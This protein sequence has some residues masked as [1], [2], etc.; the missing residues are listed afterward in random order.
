MPE[1]LRVLLGLGKGEIPSDGVT[2]LELAGLPHGWWAIPALL[3]VVLALVLV[4]LIYRRESELALPQRIVLASLRL[5]ALAL[6]VLVLLNPRLLVEI[7]A[8]RPAQTILLVDGSLSMGT[9]DRY[10]P[11][12]V[13]LLQRATGIRV[14]GGRDSEDPHG[15]ARADLVAAALLWADLPARLGKVNRLRPFIFDEKAM[16]V[17][18]KALAPSIRAA[19]RA[20]KATWL[21]SAIREALDAAGTEQ[22]AAMVV[23]SDGRSNGGD[24]PEGARAELA[25]RGIPVHAIGVGKAE[26]RKNITVAEVTAPEVAEI[27]LPLKVRV[28]VRATGLPGR[29]EVKLSRARA[30]AREF[31][32]VGAE[33]ATLKATTTEVVINFTDVPPRDGRWR[34]LAEVQPVPGEENVRD[35]RKTADV[36][37]ASEKCR[38][39]LIS[40]SPSFEFHYLKG[41]FI[42]DPGIQVSSWLQSADPESPQEGDLPLKALPSTDSELQAYDLV[43]MLDPDPSVFPAGMGAALSRFVAEGGGGLAFVAGE[44]HTAELGTS[45]E[46]REVLA[47]LPVKVPASDPGHDHRRAW[48]ARLTAAGAGHALSQLAGSAEEN[49]H[50]WSILPR[51]YFLYPTGGLKPAA[52]AL[53]ES[54]KSTV[55]AVHQAGAGRVLFAAT[56]DLW[57]WREYKVEVHEQFWSGAARFL[58]LGKR[59]AGTR[60]STIA[61]DRERY[62]PGEDVRI[63]AHL[64]DGSRKPIAASQVAVVLELVEP[65]PDPA[66]GAAPASVDP[67]PEPAD[68]APL[69]QEV[70][71]EAVRER[72]GSFRGRFKAEALGAYRVSI[73]GSEGVPAAFKVLPPAGEADDPSPDFAV[74]EDLA[75]ASGGTFRSLGELDGLAPLIP[76]RTV[77]EVLGRK[78]ATVWDSTA[79]LLAFSGALVLEWVLRKRWRLC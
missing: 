3:G 12:E 25:A 78:T 77:V 53:W 58:A 23:I 15:T 55:L 40:G 28:R 37:V 64:L 32:A 51:F 16:A 65:R 70:F 61:T 6:V 76:D 57:R 17:E 27:G 30:G 26:A 8:R 52:S 14:P 69:R 72:P 20:G 5:I 44:H 31:E 24:P 54:G 1:W 29:V 19:P 50:L 43:V 33:E 18:E 73:S 11:E 47:L 74:L 67:A 42:R 48:R 22:V 41:F 59:L 60:H 9:G 63:E 38:V 2:R 66:G 10:A 13:A 36:V 49:L 68:G 71:L 7:Q 21:G 75:R 4:V 45:A 35:N 56:D 46:G 79:L 34:Y 39:L 62:H